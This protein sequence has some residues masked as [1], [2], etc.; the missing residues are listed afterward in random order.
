M[1]AVDQERP[2]ETV[3]KV[4]VVNCLDHVD[5]NKGELNK[6]FIFSIGVPNNEESFGTEKD[7][8]RIVG[9]DAHLHSFL[10]ILSDL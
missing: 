3:L 1:L 8:P 6:S 5:K 10:A 9:S 7:V 4:S 2:L